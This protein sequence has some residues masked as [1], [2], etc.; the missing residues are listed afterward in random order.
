GVEA[1]GFP[2]PDVDI[3]LLVMARRLWQRLGIEGVELQINTIGSAE[4][5]RAF[6]G[7]LIAYFE[8]NES[9]LDEDARRRL[10]LNPM[11]ILDSKN[12]DM[13]P[14]IE[15]APRLIET[16]GPATL[17][18]FEAVQAGLRDAGIA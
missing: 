5:R 15:A 4:E 6:R 9:T 17:A 8:K 1:L 16:A 3:E 18:N 11:R 12:P 10:H 2:G 13:Q 14:L 7:K